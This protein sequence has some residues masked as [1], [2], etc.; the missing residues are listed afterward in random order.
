[1]CGR[2]TLTKGKMEIIEELSIQLWDE[3]VAYQ[4][5]YNI[6]PTNFVPI[7]VNEN[8]RVVRMMRWGLIPSWAKDQDKLPVFINARAETLFEKP[9]FSDLFDSHRC[10]VISDGYYEWKQ[11]EGRKQP[12]FIH[13]S[14]GAILPMAGLWNQWK[15]PAGEQKFTY[16]VITT[17]ANPQL[18]FIH[19]RMP[20][21]LPK[22]ALDAWLDCHD[23]PPTSAAHLLKPFS[24]DLE[25]YPV[26]NLVNS[27]RNNHLDCIAKLT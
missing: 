19:E 26:S 18:R 6:A 1:M 27:V 8:T 24:G 13:Q 15:S 21:I 9:T 5:S 22:S 10:V 25:F 17:E 2:K 14:D 20:V 12:F 7:L 16:T 23:F 4:P 11:T 3:S